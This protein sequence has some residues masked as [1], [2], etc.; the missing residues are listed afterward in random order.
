MATLDEEQ[1]SRLLGQAL[2]ARAVRLDLDPA[3]ITSPTGAVTARTTDGNLLR[4]DFR[5]YAA[6]ELA[7]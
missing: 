3:S 4:L 6:N 7:R 2:R 1:I 5:S